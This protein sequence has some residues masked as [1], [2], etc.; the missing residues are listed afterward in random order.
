M[1]LG[2]AWVH[3]LP[4]KL[5][6]ASEAGFQGIE[7]FYE[8]LEYAAKT[9]GEASPANLLQ[10]AYEVKKAC[11]SHGLT[12]I[13]LQ[14]FLFYE[15]LKDR[16]DHAV[17]IKKLKLWFQ[18]VKIFDTDIIQI[19]TNFLPADGI[20]DDLDVIVQDMAEVA[21]LGLRENPPVRFAYE[22]LAWG[23]YIDTWDGMWEVVQRVN[24]PN[25]GCC[26][27]TFNIA[28]RVWADPAS[29]T[30]KTADADRDLKASMERLLR[31][32][33]VKKVFYL[34]VVDGERMAS[35]LVEG[36]P[37]Y[38]QGQPARMSWSRNARLFLYEQEKG[39]YLPSVDVARTVLKDLGFKG[40]VSM[41]LFSRT[42]ADP[43][44]SVPHTHAQRGIKAWDT[45]REELNL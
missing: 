25:F 14:P 2:R 36:H 30:G 6:R 26:L 8:D 18:I 43:D 31:T 33:D 17:K 38:V 34:Q 4:E 41:E 10:A 21:D 27:D 37:F 11:D 13:G 22:N 45:L 15:G 39:G 3:S 24:R 12:I 32:V 23:T 7:I 20:T 9:Y 28:G 44:P 40:W 35:P 29:E 19:P 16:Q 1:S 42:M 5:A